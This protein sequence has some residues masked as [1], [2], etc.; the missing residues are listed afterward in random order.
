MDVWGPP[1]SSQPGSKMLAITPV[2][3]NSEERISV[4]NIGNGQTLFAN[5][6]SNQIRMCDEQQFCS[7]P[8]TSQSKAGLSIN[9]AGTLQFTTYSS[10]KPPGNGNGNIDKA[11]KADKA[12]NADNVDDPVIGMLYSIQAHAL[13]VDGCLEYDDTIL[14]D[15]QLGEGGYAVTHPGKF[16]IFFYIISY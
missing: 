15:V 11:D 6:I 12:D 10:N 14:M 1:P 4:F 5:V 8:A 3:I 7:I 9:S 2:I 16:F 13:N